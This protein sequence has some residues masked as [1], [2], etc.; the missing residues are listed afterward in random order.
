MLIR[1]HG[2]LSHAVEKA[3]MSSHELNDLW[4]SRTE[5]R[6][7]TFWP[8]F[9]ERALPVLG[10]NVAGGATGEEGATR[11]EPDRPEGSFVKTETTFWKVWQMALDDVSAHAIAKATDADPEL[12]FVNRDKAGVI[13]GAVA[14]NRSAARRALSGQTIPKGFSA[15]RYGVKLPSS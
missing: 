14:R 12:D 13:K 2:M 7:K 10:I 9:W 4:H 15:T 6:S 8:Y 1:E 11:G 3:I 5:W